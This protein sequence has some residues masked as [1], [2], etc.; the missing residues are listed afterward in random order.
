M[1]RSH[2]D[3][4]AGSTERADEDDS[5]VGL[6]SGTIHITGLV[7]NYFDRPFGYPFNVRLPRLLNAVLL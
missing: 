4:L 6:G 1:G 3:S 2:L 5:G 7:K